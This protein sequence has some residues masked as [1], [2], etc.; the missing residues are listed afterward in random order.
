MSSASMHRNNRVQK[1][2][3]RRRGCEKI[4][5]MHTP[6]LFDVT[7]WSMVALGLSLNLWGA[8]RTWKGVATRN[9]K[10]WPALSRLLRRDESRSDRRI[11]A[12]ASLVLKGTASGYKQYNALPP[13]SDQEAFEKE[14]NDR[15]NELYK[16][17]AEA[18]GR[19]GKE[20]AKVQRQVEDLR[21]SVNSSVSGVSHEV[22]V[23]WERVQTELLG[24]VRLE[25]IG[26][27][28][29]VFGLAANIAKALVTGA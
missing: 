21:K 12:V 6:H 13:M 16:K 20:T 19:V 10:L 18:E 2:A 4:L 1:R 25:V 22:Q 3:G 14:V 17:I 9:D 11:S 7:A 24:S 28:L 15:L 29:V 23:V 27:A 5:D 26:S 8:W